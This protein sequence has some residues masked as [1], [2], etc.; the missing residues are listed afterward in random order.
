MQYARMLT[1]MGYAIYATKGTCEMLK[2]HGI[3]SATMVYKPFVK[4]LSYIRLI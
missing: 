3:E 4:R 2:Q 1:D